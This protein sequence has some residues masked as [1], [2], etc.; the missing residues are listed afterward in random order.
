[1]PDT[2]R[3]T[4]DRLRGLVDHRPLDTESRLRTLPRR[5]RGPS[6]Q[7]IVA[8]V[9]AFAVAATAIGLAAYAFLHGSKP[10]RPASTRGG[11]IVVGSDWP[12][13]LNP[14]NGC[15]SATGAWWTVLQHVLPH[16]MV[17]D[18]GGYW[19]AS[20]LLVEAPSL[21]NGG[22]TE[23]PFTVTYHL[24]PKAIWADGTPITSSDFEFT[25][26]ALMNTEAAYNTAG[27]E[28]IESI[29]ATDPKT[30]VIRFTE[31]YVDWPDL[32][33][34]PY[35]GVLEKA[36]FPRFADDP[37]PNLKDEMR[38]SIPFSGGPW[39]LKSWSIA[40]AV[41]IRNDRYYGQ[42]ALLD[43]VTFVPLFQDDVFQPLIGGDVALIQVYSEDVNLFSRASL[44]NVRGAGGDGLTFEA[45]WLNQDFPP[46]DDRKV[47][48]A[49][50]Y[51][52]D[53][54]VVIDALVKAL[55]P[56]VEILNCGFIAF[57]KVGPW[58]QTRPFE[59]FTYDPE[60]ARSILESAGYECSTMPCTKNGEKLVVEF[61]TV[62]TNRR[63]TATQD[64]LKDKALRAGIKLRIKNYDAGTLF[65]EIGPRGK[66]MIAEYASGG[67]VP[68][69][70]VTSTLACKSIPTK[71]NRFDGMN[72]SHWCNQRAA[73]L[74][75][76]SDRELDPG[77]RLQLM[78]EI[79]RLQAQDFVLLPLYV[80]P[81][82]TFWRT[83][84]VAGPITTFISSPN[85]PF[86]NL[87][88]WHVPKGSPSG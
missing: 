10:P 75:D 32:F 52:I 67:A 70:T 34:G 9:V 39:V 81:Q 18:E 55:N 82:V 40:R 64:L 28:L 62:A 86:W 69:P 77:K 54:Q 53:R 57:P 17:L 1:M 20:P 49:L 76:L 56:D 58:C 26:R 13:C 42:K 29:D 6:R 68:D 38:Q 5:S 61:S 83:D 51:A 84:R 87:D 23:D 78:T 4:H 19:I 60:K 85:G 50:M 11:S 79:Y 8:A 74:M 14:L 22:L 48:E 47:R 37:K 41:L 63:R 73:E 88:E 27:Y 3:D 25:W 15:A 46:L 21:A 2:D 30:V 45:L 35:G 33:G 31:V 7:R 16:A 66:F 72:W 24:N 59:R 12:E 80:T 44:P 65:D 43:Q 71:R 36:A